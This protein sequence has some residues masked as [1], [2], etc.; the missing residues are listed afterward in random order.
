MNAT[1]AVHIHPKKQSAFSTFRNFPVGRFF[2][3]LRPPLER[4]NSC[5]TICIAEASG[6]NVSALRIPS[7]KVSPNAQGD[8]N[9]NCRDADAN[10]SHRPTKWTSYLELQPP[11]TEA[12]RG[13]N[14]SPNDDEAVGN[15][16]DGSVA[17]GGSNTTPRPSPPPEFGND[18]SQINQANHEVHRREGGGSFFPRGNLRPAIAPRSIITRHSSRDISLRKRPKKTAPQPPSAPPPPPPIAAVRRHIE[19]LQAAAKT[20]D[21]HRKEEN[22]LVCQIVRSCTPGKETVTQVTGESISTLQTSTDAENNHDKICSGPEKN[23]K[24]EVKIVS[25][26][27]NFPQKEQLSEHRNE[28]VTSTSSEP[29]TY[30]LVSTVTCNNGEQERKDL[31]CFTL[32]NIGESCTDDVLP[33]CSNKTSEVYGNKNNNGSLNIAHNVDNS[34][35]Q[36]HFEETKS[37]LSVRNNQITHPTGNL[38]RSYASVHIVNSEICNKRNTGDHNN[39]APQ[40]DSRNARESG[41]LINSLSDENSF[42]KSECNRISIKEND[43]GLSVINKKSDD[44]SPAEIV[45]KIPERLNKTSETSSLLQETLHNSEGNC[46]KSS[47]GSTNEPHG[48]NTSQTIVNQTTHCATTL[49]SKDSPD[50][51]SCS[52]ILKSSEPGKNIANKPTDFPCLKIVI[53]SPNEKYI[54]S[55]STQRNDCTSYFVTRCNNNFDQTNNQSSEVPIIFSKVRTQNE[56]SINLITV[57]GSNNFS[58]FH[59]QQ[60]R[61]DSESNISPNTSESVGINRGITV[62]TERN[63]ASQVSAECSQRDHLTI[64][65]RNNFG[66][67]V[68]IKTNNDSENIYQNINC[69][70][71]EQVNERQITFNGEASVSFENRENKHIPKDSTS[72]REIANANEDVLNNKSTNRIHR[73]AYIKAIKAECTKLDYLHTNGNHLP[74]FEGDIKSAALH[75]GFLDVANNNLWTAKIQENYKD[76]K[77]NG[78]MGPSTNHELL[79]LGEISCGSSTSDLSVRDINECYNVKLDAPEEVIVAGFHDFCQTMLS[80]DDSPVE[81][82]ENETANGHVVQVNIKTDTKIMQNYNGVNKQFLQNGHALNFYE[83]PYIPGASPFVRSLARTSGNPRESLK[84]QSSH[85]TEGHEVSSD[86]LL[87]EIQNSKCMEKKLNVD[88]PAVLKVLR[89]LDDSFTEADS[90]EISNSDSNWEGMDQ[91]RQ[92]NVILEIKNAPPKNSRDDK[93]QCDNLIEE[94]LLKDIKKIIQ[95]SVEKGCTPAPPPQNSERG[96][97]VR[98]SN[99]NAQSSNLQQEQIKNLE[100]QETTK[101]NQVSHMDNNREKYQEKARQGCDVVNRDQNFPTTTNEKQCPMTAQ[102]NGNSNFVPSVNN[103]HYIPN[104]K[105]RSQEV[106]KVNNTDT[107]ASGGASSDPTVLSGEPKVPPPTTPLRVSVDSSQGPNGQDIAAFHNRTSPCSVDSGTSSHNQ[108]YFVVVAIDF[109]TTYS[110]YAFSFTRD[111][112]NIHMMKMWDGGDPGVFNQ[113]T[114]TTLLLT[115]EGAFHSFGYS[116]RDYYHDLDSEEAKQWMY[117]DKFK[118]TLHNNEHLSLETE[119]KAANGKPMLAVTV[120]A[121]ALRYFK[122]QALQELSDQSATKILNEDLRWVVTVPAIWKQPAKQFMRAAAYKAGIA[123]AEFSDQLLIA[124]EPEAASIYCRKMRLHHLVPAELQGQ[125]DSLLMKQDD[126]SLGPDGPT[127]GDKGTRYMVVDCGGGTV[128]ITVHEVLDSHGTLKELQRASGGPYGSV[129]VDMEFEKLLCDIFGADFIQQFK[130]KCPTGY[131]D[132]MIAF[133]ARKRNASPYK[134]N[135]L[136]ISLP[137]SFIDYFKKFKGISVETAMKKSSHKDVRWSQGMLRLEKSA[138]VQ[139]FSKTV[140][141]IR[142]H[143]ASILSVPELNIDYLFLV[144]GFAES[145]ILQ[146]E[147]KDAFSSK[148]KV[149]IPQGVSLAIL[150][151]AVLFGLDPTIVN[152]RR[153]RMTYGVGVLNRFIHGI[154][155]PEKLVVK[156]GIQWCA[157]IFDK[158]VVTDQSIGLGDVIVR[159][160][161]PAKAGQSCSVIHMYCSEKDNVYFITDHGVKRCA[162]LILDLS[163]NR[164]IQSREIQTRMM[165]GDTEIKVSALDVT[166][167]KCVKAEVDFLGH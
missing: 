44:S 137:F 158:F 25:E 9:V 30:N 114:P 111:P 52:E 160:Y 110:G 166:T 21:I 27:N 42:S 118:M 46:Q 115:P 55:D 5:P 93:I 48:N 101:T 59:Q 156:D 102:S 90:N 141:Q 61:S 129:G 135:P 108:G 142:D 68:H 116:A 36:T 113:K 128:D 40:L 76:K 81:Q 120:F 109:G 121:H 3:F 167:G 14:S 84:K 26:G 162:T 10:S 41:A 71:T 144:G 85:V 43:A 138:M 163:D 140:S 35:L 95:N 136:N 65:E 39:N 87:E 78:F 1:V 60:R 124:L 4:R 159:S 77:E 24:L 148:L 164:F 83:R 97:A 106:K 64:S 127:L 132:L 139:L 72:N 143:I 11:E 73:D 150:K 86:K 105:S 50:S 45:E 70:Q 23:Y 54:Y 157:D 7:R 67:A 2:K 22:G 94:V 99:T 29:A 130:M 119:I 20:P 63:D 165:F 49:I 131:V 47:A 117:F 53:H 19:K 31:N 89:T 82:S 152:V 6:D 126:H 38:S 146:K 66:K 100:T 17:E 125:R 122:E 51:K 16:R 37:A 74:I 18:S 8:I 79:D 34:Q 80:V 123:S 58:E 161:T 133:E 62:T 92:G 88:D 32:E 75:N 103:M 13:N 56:K 91:K 15:N 145:L 33:S 96:I 147:V 112:E 57:N 69:S 12:A 98:I 153:L 134:E 104:F 149:V 155:P 151:G 154:H 107:D 28:T